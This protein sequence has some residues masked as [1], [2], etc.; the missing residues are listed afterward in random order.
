MTHK[1]IFFPSNVPW[2]FGGR[3]FCPVT[4]LQL[5]KNMVFCHFWCLFFSFLT[6]V[7]SDLSNYHREYSPYGSYFLFQFER[8]DVI[9]VLENSIE[10]SFVFFKR[11]L[12]FYMNRTYELLQRP[13]VCLLT[14]KITAFFLNQQSLFNISKRGK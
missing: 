1:S 2:T 13:K 10:F 3:G 5:L 11:L 12:N 9:S 14:K 7:A 4:F 8:S 6:L